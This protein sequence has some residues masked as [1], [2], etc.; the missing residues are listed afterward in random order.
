MNK[1]PNQWQ[2]AQMSEQMN[3]WTNEQMNNWTNKQMNKWTNEPTE[4]ER[5]EIFFLF[6]VGFIRNQKGLAGRCWWTRIDGR[7]RTTMRRMRMERKDND[8][9][10][11]DGWGGWMRKDNDWWGGWMRMDE[12]RKDNDVDEEDGCWTLDEENLISLRER[13]YRV[14]SCF[15]FLLSCICTKTSIKRLKEVWLLFF[16]SPRLWKKRWGFLKRHPA[17]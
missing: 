13:F 14:L 9:E 12:E 10:D 6:V 16:E 17:F 8:E 4:R 11:D 2:S 3:K 1:D 5:T 15:L 7:G